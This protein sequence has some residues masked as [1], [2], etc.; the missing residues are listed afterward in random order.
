MAQRRTAPGAGAG[1]SRKVILYASLGIM[2]V[3]VIVAVALASRVPKVASTAP[4]SAQLTIGQPAPTFTLPTTNG[5]FDLAQASGKP[6]LLE[7]FATWCPHCQRET[8]VLNTI[9]DAYKDKVHIVAVSGSQYG[10][11]GNSPESQADVV[12]FAQKYKVRYPI[13][14]DP[15]LDVAN[16]Y[17][18]G[19]F[20]TLVLISKDGKI[21]KFRDGEIPIEEIKKDLNEALGG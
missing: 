18:Q 10:V 14:Y 11:D 15:T 20:P 17:L 6:V 16:K 9:Y 19:G 7:V 13:A 1:N 2:V 3:I 12:E 4:I 5:V 21:L 8:G